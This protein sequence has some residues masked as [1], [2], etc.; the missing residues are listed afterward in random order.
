M[1]GAPVVALALALLLCGC[2]RLTRGVVVSKDHHPAYSHRQPAAGGKV[3]RRHHHPERWT[4]DL[5]GDHEGKRRRETYSV[6]ESFFEW[7][8][9]GDYC[10]IDPE[11]GSLKC[12]RDVR[13]ERPL[14]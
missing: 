7:V 10:E 3:S 8:H 14:R 2:H 6:G 13:A 11:D 5:L 4:V 9:V 12:W 1:R